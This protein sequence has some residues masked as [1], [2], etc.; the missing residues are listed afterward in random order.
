MD[1]RKILGIIFIILGIIFAVYPMYS[2][3]AVSFIAGISLIALGFAFFMD[4]FS[5]LSMMTHYSVIEIL[6]GM[7][8]IIFGL[9]FIY[10]IDALSFLVA[11][12][13]YLVGFVLIFM[14]LVNMFTL[15]GTIP[16]FTA[17]L[18]LILGIVTVLLAA[19]SLAQPVYVAIIVGICLIMEGILFLTAGIT[20]N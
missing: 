11:F 8:A 14:G 2:A 7:L 3:T 20:E 17:I 19:F 15:P 13:F 18:T 6:L 12:N 1:Y 4:A 16:K 9:L 5:L 10:E